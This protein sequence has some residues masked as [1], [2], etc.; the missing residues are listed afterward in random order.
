MLKPILVLLVLFAAGCA[1][2]QSKSETKDMQT[3]VTET[4]QVQLQLNN[5]QKWQL[6]EATRQHMKDIKAYVAQATHANGELNG[7]ELQKYADR[8]IK[9]CRMSGPARNALDDWMRPFLQHVDALKNNRD[10]ESASHALNED[11]KVFDTYF[12]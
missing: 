6:D 2:N 5:G 10:A 8:L 11:V 7:A 12:E 3:P 1:N 9:D 4:N